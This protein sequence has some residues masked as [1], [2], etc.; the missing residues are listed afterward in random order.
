[1]RRR[2]EHAGAQLAG[3]ARLQGSSRP[4][5]FS[6]LTSSSRRFFIARWCSTRF[7]S[8]TQNYQHTAHRSTQKAQVGVHTS[9]RPPHRSSSSLWTTN[10]RTAKHVVPRVITKAFWLSVSSPK[11]SLGGRGG[12]WTAAACGPAAVGSARVGVNTRTDTRAETLSRRGSQPCVLTT[13]EPQPEAEQG[14]E[15]ARKVAA[16]LDADE[17]HTA[18]APLVTEPPTWR[19]GTRRWCR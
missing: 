18:L 5:S 4:G 14:A 7:C 13:R 17:P 11:R 3:W 16:A 9:C 12:M 1:M 19:C 15:T 6:C 10:P 2:T 8:G